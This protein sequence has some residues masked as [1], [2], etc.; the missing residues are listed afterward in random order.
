[1]MMMLLLMMMMIAT[2]TQ[3]TNTIGQFVP[4]SLEPM[5][6]MMMR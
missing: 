3:K 4:L 5:I 2:T 1:M 6:M